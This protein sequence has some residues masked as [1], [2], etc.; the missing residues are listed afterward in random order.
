MPAPLPPPPPPSPPP[1]SQTL[2][3]RYLQARDGTLM[4]RF[5]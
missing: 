1:R 2:T 4:A 3:G 5:K